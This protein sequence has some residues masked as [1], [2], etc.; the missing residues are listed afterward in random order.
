MGSNLCLPE[1]LYHF[2]GKVLTGNVTSNAFN[3]QS[4]QVPMWGNG[5]SL[6]TCIPYHYNGYR[7]LMYY[8]GRL[9]REKK[10]DLLISWIE[11]GWAEVQQIQGL[12]LSHFFPLVEERG[13]ASSNPIGD[14]PLSQNFGGVT[15]PPLSSNNVF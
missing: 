8:M 2:Q 3:T 1:T 14:L 5:I 13:H 7:V 11:G 9:M 10:E 4:T 6:V 12:S 15:P